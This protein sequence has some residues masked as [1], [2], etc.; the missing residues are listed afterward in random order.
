MRAVLRTTSPRGVAPPVTDDCAPIGSTAAV[1]AQ[2]RGHF[3]LVA[4]EDDA[5]RVRRPGS[6]RRPRGT[7]AR[8]RDR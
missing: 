7:T 4:R 6:A 1:R 8:C 3:G 2:H 5:G